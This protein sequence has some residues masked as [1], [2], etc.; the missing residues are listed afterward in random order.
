[1]KTTK[2]RNV[3]VIPGNS[4]S[5]NSKQKIKKRKKEKMGK[6]V[7]SKNYSFT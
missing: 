1:M 6:A 3:Y 7:K 5:N 4:D 2:D